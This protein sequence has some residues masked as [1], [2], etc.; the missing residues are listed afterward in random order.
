MTADNATG[1][2]RAL[3]LCCSLTP[4]PAAS[5]SELMAR[6]VLDGLAEQGVVGDL[7]R[8]VDYNVMPGVQVDMGDGD[9]WPGLRERMLAADILVFATPTWLGHH[10]SVAQ[11]VLERLDAELSETDDSGRKLT[12]GKVA[13]VAA[14]GNEDGAHKIIA[15]CFQALNDL[16][17]TI[18]SNGSVYWNANIEHPA[19]Y[20]DLEKVPD[21]VA[22]MLRQAT[23]DSTHLA[24]H[25]AEQ[26]YPPAS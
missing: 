7:A 11:R 14:V 17:F 18:A 24:R 19:D 16:G 4:S 1:E 2:L 3:A 12:S 6:Q 15:D 13:I 9:E 10:S 20:R 8:V 25:L 22:S 21:A 23:R 26:G 5:S